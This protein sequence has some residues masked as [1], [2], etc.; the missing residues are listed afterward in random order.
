MVHS[1]ENVT[2]TLQI[3]K[4]TVKIPDFLKIGLLTHTLVDSTMHTL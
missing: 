2:L 3:M 1:L 4:F